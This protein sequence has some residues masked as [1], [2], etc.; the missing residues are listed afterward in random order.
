MWLQLIF[1]F[2]K[3]TIR[4]IWDTHINT[5]KIKLLSLSILKKN[6]IDPTFQN[7]TKT[8]KS[9]ILKEVIICIQE[10]VFLCTGIHCKNALQSTFS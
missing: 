9:C 4:T 3:P 7:K 10:N 8:N 2:P 1:L 6:S 5:L